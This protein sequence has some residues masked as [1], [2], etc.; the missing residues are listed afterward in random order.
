MGRRDQA[1]RRLRRALLAARSPFLLRTS[2]PIGKNWG[3]DRGTPVDRFYIEAFLERHHRDVRGRVLEIKDASYTRRFGSSVTRSDV[4]DVDPANAAAT[5]HADLAAAEGVPSSSFD[6]V[7]LTQTLQLIFDLRAALAHLH[8]VLA[9]DGV[10]L[11]TVPTLS[12]L[13]QPGT[14]GTDY[15]RFTPAGCTELF[16]AE[17]GFEHVL[18]E[19]LGNVLAGVAFLHGLAAEELSEKKLE[20]H[21]PDFPLVV[22]VRALKRA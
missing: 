19:P 17:F 21:D 4:L 2:A 5:L 14:E 18:V 22:G 1:R 6:C 16:G 13:V 7:I 20:Q 12:R 9:P 10:L 3:W 11:A 15:W 8:R